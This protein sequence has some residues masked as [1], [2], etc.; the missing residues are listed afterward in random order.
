MS[1]PASR[2]ATTCPNSRQGRGERSPSGRDDAACVPAPPLTER[3]AEEQA[4]GICFKTGP[5][6]QVGVELEWLVKDFRDP[7]PPVDQQRGAAA[8]ARLDAPR[9]LPGECRLTTE[10]GGQVELSS[11]AAP[12][13]GACVT[14]AADDLASAHG[15]RGPVGR[16]HV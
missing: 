8:L 7:A 16:A 15:W 5:P 11:A 9:A 13:L 3:G 12:R 2:F 14:A 1:E 6:G 4:H 10:P